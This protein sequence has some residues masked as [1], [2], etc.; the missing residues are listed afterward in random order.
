M[1]GSSSALFKAAVEMRS[2]DEPS[3]GLVA[4]V[5]VKPH[6]G[7]PRVLTLLVE[8]HEGATRARTT[9]AS[10]GFVMCRSAAPAP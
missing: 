3:Q 6:L 2:G 1:N 8:L 10:K 9:S 5:C 7:A 4:L